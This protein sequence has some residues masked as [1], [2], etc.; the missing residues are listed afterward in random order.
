MAAVLIG[1][2]TKTTTTTRPHKI[3]KDHRAWYTVYF[4]RHKPQTL[5]SKLQRNFLCV[6]NLQSLHSHT[7]IYGQIR[8]K[9]RFYHTYNSRTT[10]SQWQG[11]PHVT[12]RTVMTVNVKWMAAIFV[13]ATG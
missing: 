9:K 7:V 12:Q 10:H 2:T 4:S 3:H 5:W 1:P 13:Q 11:V 8:T 6:A